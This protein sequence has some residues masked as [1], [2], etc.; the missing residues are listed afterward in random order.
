MLNNNNLSVDICIFSVED[1]INMLNEP[2]VLN[3]AC[4]LSYFLYALFVVV[5]DP[6]HVLQ[7]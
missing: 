5:Y 4:Q 1:M 6:C 3:M 2:F 7:P